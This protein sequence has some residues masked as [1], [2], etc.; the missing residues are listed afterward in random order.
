[1]K[2]LL[3]GPTLPPITGQS[4]AFTRVCEALDVGTYDVINTNLE[5]KGKYQKIFHTFFIM[6][7]II[8]KLLKNDYDKV[9][10]TCTRSLGGSLKDIVLIYMASL[11]KIPVINHL[12]GSDFYDFLHTAPKIYKKIL[13]NAYQKVNTSIVLLDP[14]RDQFRDF[15]NMNIKVIPNFYDENLDT[16]EPQKNEKTISV[17]YLSNIM[18]SKGIF[19]LIEAFCRMDKEYSIRLDIAGGFLGDELMNK[20]ETQK[21]FLDSIGTCPHIVY[22][23]VVLGES[24]MKL[25]QQSDIFVLPSYYKSEAFPISIL[26]AMRCGNAIITTRYKYLPTIVS[27][28]NGLLV[29]TKSISELSDAIEILLKDR[30]RLEQIQQHNRIEAQQNFSLSTYI[31]NIKSVLL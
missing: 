2:F 30:S 18:K 26:E 24:K 4:L 9:Y 29:E 22:H 7:N 13:F 21:L 12:H 31:A 20:Q 27:E 17:L 6:A 5:S 23:G 1:M 14:M 8:Y 11:R 15:P 10:F 28:Q 3:V 19:E 25:L 16:K